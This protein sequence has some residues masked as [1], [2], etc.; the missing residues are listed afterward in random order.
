M[1]NTNTFLEAKWRDRTI[2]NS[3]NQQWYQSKILGKPLRKLSQTEFLQRQIKREKEERIGRCMRQIT[4]DC[5]IMLKKKLQ[6]IEAFNS[7]LSGNKYMNYNCF[8]CNQNGHIMKTCPT[9]SKDDKARTQD[10]SGGIMEGNKGNPLQSEFTLDKNR[11]L[12]FKCRKDGHFANKCPPEN[13][14]HP[15]VSLKYPEFI[16]FQTNGIVERT[17]KD[18][19][20]N[21]WY[22]SITSDKHLTSNLKFFSNLKEEF[23]VKKLE[24]QRKFLFTYG[25]GEVLIKNGSNGFLI[26]GVHY[27]PE[28]TLNIL[29][30][31]LLKQQGVNVIFEKDK[32][33]LE[34]M[35]K[36]QQGQNMDEDKMR[37]RHNDY[38]DDYFESLN[39]EETDKE[40]E[41][42]RYLEETNTSEVHTFQE[43]VA[44]LNLIKNND[45]ISKEWGIYR[46][47][48]DKVLK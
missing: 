18:G 12:C 28:V 42:P 1:V 16:H 13:Q 37:Q 43:F 14:D 34:Y 33:F 23:L 30:I 2:H 8:Y 48:F 10:I 9:K 19:W 24:G 38:L 35:F 44:F 46:E 17:D 3:H 21:F 15:K 4:K 20:D 45:V 40:E 25:M 36:N 41:I 11:I 22:V 29:S 47:R 31:N 7:S 6:D 39:K 26:P 32:C 27:A 5:R